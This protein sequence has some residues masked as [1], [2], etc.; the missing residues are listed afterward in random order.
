MSGSGQS[1]MSR[2]ASERRP[3]IS[4]GDVETMTAPCTNRAERLSWTNGA[5][6]RSEQ[7]VVSTVTIHGFRIQSYGRLSAGFRRALKR[8]AAKHFKD[9]SCVVV[10]TR[11]G[12]HS[13]ITHFGG[14]YV[15][16]QNPYAQ[17]VVRLMLDAGM[18]PPPP[19]FVV[20]PG[21]FTLYHEWGHHVDR[22]WS[23]D[24]QDVPFSFRWFSHF[25]RIGSRLSS[26]H[27]SAERGGEVGRIET[28]RA[29]VD[30]ILQWKLVS[31]ELFANLFEDWL[32]G[33]RR[34]TGRKP[35]QPAI[36]ASAISEG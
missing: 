5:S 16:P 23:L 6:R 31:S 20:A 24:D 10:K 22:V 3:F 7:S 1:A 14:R 13:G 2:T 36:L 26:K 21:E 32:R 35:R 30:A 12:N 27:S 17:E 9:E 19:P 11:W 8:L 4:L 28:E 33:E 18:D 15:H 29:A 34:V 25:Y